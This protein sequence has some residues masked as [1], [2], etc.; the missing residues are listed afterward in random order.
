MRLAEPVPELVDGDRLE[1]DVAHAVV[2]VGKAWVVVDL[3][4][5]DVCAAVAIDVG[6]VTG[7]CNEDESERNA[8]DQAPEVDVAQAGMLYVREDERGRPTETIQ[9]CDDTDI[10][11]KARVRCDRQI[12][13][14]HRLP[15][16]DPSQDR[17]GGLRAREPAENR[18]YVGGLVDREGDVVQRTRYAAAPVRP[19]RV[20]RNEVVVETLV[21]YAARE[22]DRSCLATIWRGEIFGD[23]DPIAGARHR[24][25]RVDGI[26][27]RQNLVGSPPAGC[28]Q[29]G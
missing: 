15:A 24:E 4:E 12:R 25:P 17:C 21:A 9:E 18:G 23:G 14:L 10:Q 22:D 29:G 6:G 7:V 28:G 5:R 11:A 20:E 13:A 8:E 19:S 2:A 16:G 3:A 26:H 1:V 27:Q